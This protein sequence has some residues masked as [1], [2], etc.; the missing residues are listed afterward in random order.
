MLCRAIRSALRILATH[1]FPF[2]HGN[3]KYKDAAA[4]QNTN[5]SASDQCAKIAIVVIYSVSKSA[6]IERM[7]TTRSEAHTSRDAGDHWP[8]QHR[9][10]SS[11]NAT[12][13]GPNP[14]ISATDP[15]TEDR[16]VV[17]KIGGDRVRDGLPNGI[18]RSRFG[19]EWP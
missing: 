14:P 8:P 4:K 19:R 18:G 5:S 15:R 16:P 7:A 10:V 3:K 13:Q 6:S 2:P 17:A 11:R 1:V 12:K 9:V